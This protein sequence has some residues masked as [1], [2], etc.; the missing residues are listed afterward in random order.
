MASIKILV[1]ETKSFLF[2]NF[3]LKMF[4]KV[5]FPLSIIKVYAHDGN[6]ITFGF[7]TIR[8]NKTEHK[9]EGK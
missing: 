3:G 8:D 7:I 9:N 1:S 4:G 6:S 5:I 2:F